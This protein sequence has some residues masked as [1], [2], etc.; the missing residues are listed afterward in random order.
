MRYLWVVML[1][2]VAGKAMAEHYRIMSYNVEN[3]FDCRDDSLKNDDDFLEEGM[4]HWTQGR[5][6]TKL[7]QIATVIAT[8]GGWQPPAIV[9]L[10]EVETK[11]C[12]QDLCLYCLPKRNYPYQIVHFEGPDV[13]GV[14]AALLFDSTRLQLLEAS[15]I[16]IGLPE[17]ERPTRDILY[18]SLLRLKEQ[19]TLHCYVCH[20]PS[21]LGGAAETA[22]KRDR[23]FSTLHLHIDSV[24]NTS[25]GAKIVVMGDFNSAPA[26]RLAPMTNLMLRDVECPRE[27]A[28]T[29]KFHG[30]WSMLD[31]F[32]ISPELGDI[33]AHIFAPE[34]LLE[35]DNQYLGYKPYRTFV[36]PR[37][38]KGYSDHLP[39]YL[40]LQPR[41]Q[42][43]I[44]VR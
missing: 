30:E 3:L 13:R 14:D 9:G 22:E 36:G 18:A 20:F 28:G 15:P 1:C 34:W 41:G 5:Y 23:A 38:N 37:Y 31:Q 11:E 21:Q 32:Y 4:Y 12:L 27:A 29:H 26:D 7:H 42:M 19:D 33:K 25:H 44:D 24:R 40:D 17:G 43:K 8:V 35:V 2:L 6:Y 10:M 16:R 39:I